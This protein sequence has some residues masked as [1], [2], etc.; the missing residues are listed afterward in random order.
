MARRRGNH[1]GGLYQ[2]KHRLWCAQVSLNGRSLTKY[3]R[4]S[5]ECRE[6]IKETLARIDS[7][8]SYDASRITLEQF[9]EV[10]LGV[11]NFPSDQ[12]LSRAIAE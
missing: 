4:S 6:W 8:L 9:M 1:E 10:G 12:R 7:G 2:R 11:R 5:T 3:S